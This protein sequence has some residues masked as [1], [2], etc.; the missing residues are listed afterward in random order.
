MEAL[1]PPL[2]R[3]TTKIVRPIT[4]VNTKIEPS[5]IPRA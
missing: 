1:C 4:W 2:M 5:V 3:L